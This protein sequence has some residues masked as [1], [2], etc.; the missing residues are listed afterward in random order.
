MNLHSYLDLHMF[1][2]HVPYTMGR[3]LRILKEKKKSAQDRL[4]TCVSDVHITWLIGAPSLLNV[5]KQQP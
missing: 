3:H 2:L 5:P 1:R 4:D